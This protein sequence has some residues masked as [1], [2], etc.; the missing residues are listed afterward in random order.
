MKN[1]TILRDTV[2]LD[3]DDCRLKLVTRIRGGPPLIKRN[4][5]LPDIDAAWVY[6]LSEFINASR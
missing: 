2:L 6:E 4:V 1:G 3:R 5:I